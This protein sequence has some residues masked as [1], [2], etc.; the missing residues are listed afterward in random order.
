MAGLAKEYDKLASQLR[1]AH[2]QV[3]KMHKLHLLSIQ[4]RHA[5]AMPIEEAFRKVS[6]EKNRGGR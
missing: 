1:A 3:D 4:Q 2:A 5:I 6:Y